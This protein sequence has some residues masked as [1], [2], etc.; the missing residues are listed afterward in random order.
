MTRPKETETVRE[1]IIQFDIA[2]D[3]LAGS[4]CEFLDMGFD[5]DAF[6]TPCE[7]IFRHLV[8]DLGFDYG[9]IREEAYKRA[10]EGEE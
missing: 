8:E 6:F 9:E 5:L 10:K 1:R 3:R 7:R 2:F 4:L